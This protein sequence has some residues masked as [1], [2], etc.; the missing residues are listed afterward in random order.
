MVRVELKDEIKRMLKEGY[1]YRQI[2]EALGVGHW[3][4]HKVK[5][6]LE[7]EEEERR[8]REAWAKVLPKWE[9]EFKRLVR[10]SGLG[11]VKLSEDDLKVLWDYWDRMELDIEFERLLDKYVE[12]CVKPLLVWLECY[13]GLLERW[14]AGL[15]GLLRV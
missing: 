14:T 7:R 9:Q 3:T 2:R 4:I 1:T 13:A 15:F 10:K 11:K 5:L 12:V 8:L 6:E